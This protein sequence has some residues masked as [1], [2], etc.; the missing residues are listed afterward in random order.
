MCPRRAFLVPSGST[1]HPRWN[2]EEQAE[3]QADKQKRPLECGPLA[4]GLTPSCVIP[5][6]AGIQFLP[7]MDPRFRGGDVLT[8][9]SLAGPPAQVRPVESHVIPAEAGIQFLPDMDPRFGGGDVLTFI[10]LGGPPAQ[11]RPVES[12]V[13]P[14]KAGIQFLPDVDPRFRG[15]DVLTFI[16]LGGPPPQVRSE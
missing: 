10:S 2:D 12:H 1:Q 16:S 15:G 7:D 8:F 9:I 5:A 13:I 11:V 3:N 4:K 6:E 14:A